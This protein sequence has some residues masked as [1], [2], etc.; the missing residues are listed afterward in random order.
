MLKS[1]KE[2][3]AIGFSGRRLE[4][5]C[6]TFSLPSGGQ[7]ILRPAANAGWSAEG[8]PLRDLKIE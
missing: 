8:A 1:G 5:E 7:V 2:V 3:K 4:T 6:G